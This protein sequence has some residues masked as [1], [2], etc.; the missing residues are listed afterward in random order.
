MRNIIR[1]ACLVTLVVA[2]SGCNKDNFGNSGQGIIIKGKIGAGG[3]AKNLESSKSADL[4]TLN[5]ATKV[6]VFSKYYYS[7][8]DITNGS[9]SVSAQAGSGAALIFLDASNKYIGTLS[10][11][12][13]NVLPLGNL[14][15]GDD[16]MIDLSTLTLEGTNVIPSHDPFGN[17]IRISQSE[18]DCLKAIS[19]YYE[20]I[21]KN[22]DS[23]N[24]GN[25]DV[26]T[27]R[28][29]V[30]YTMF[31]VFAGHFGF[32]N[33]IPVVNDANHYYVNYML[34]VAAG[35]ALNFSNENISFSGPEVDS[36]SDIKMWGY[37]KSPGGDRSFIASFCRETQAQQGA[38]W[39]SGFLP[40]KKGRYTLT[41][42]GTQKFTLDYSNIGI[43]YNLVLVIPT[44]HTNSDGKLTSITFEY[45]LPDGTIIDPGNVLTNVM[46]QLSNNHA[47]QFYVNDRNKLNSNTGFSVLTIDP[48]QDIST[49]FQMDLWYDDLLGN[50]YD[51]IWR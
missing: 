28:Q 5:D 9:F 21:A 16:T 43:S 48:P 34:E 18:I 24:D 7:L 33:S 32:N 13:L 44:M 25:P 27:N 31:S 46:V 17:E 14:S 40:F 10:S 36:Y 37:K 35:S 47:G 11:R 20:S 41:L 49:L 3:T 2:V 29:V 22:I 8:N 39:G 30:I 51:I 45:R 19:G 1:L 4:L 26:L 12:G 50:Q 15:G 42:D 6:L 23:D 38:P